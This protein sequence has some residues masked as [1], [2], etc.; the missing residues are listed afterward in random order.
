LL[1]PSISLHSSLHP[2]LYPLLSI[3]PFLSP[4]FL[5]SSLFIHRSLHPSLFLH[6]FLSLTKYGLGFSPVR[7][8]NEI[9]VI[10]FHNDFIMRYK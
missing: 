8:S 2:F 6:P 7:E 4:S 9:P 3:N 5:N 1:Y 10:Q